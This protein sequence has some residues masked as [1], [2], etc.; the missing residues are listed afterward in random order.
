MSWNRGSK[1]KMDGT[2]GRFRR[3]VIGVR[4]SGPTTL[5]KRSIDTV[6]W[7]LSTAKSRT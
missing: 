3:W 5:L 7:G 6:T 4:I 1:P 2:T